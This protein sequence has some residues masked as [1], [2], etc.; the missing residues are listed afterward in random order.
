LQFH[1]ARLLKIR[2]PFIEELEDA[3]KDGYDT[4]F[5]SVETE[6]RGILSEL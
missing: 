1:Y 5:K 4:L 2:V 6:L 3:F